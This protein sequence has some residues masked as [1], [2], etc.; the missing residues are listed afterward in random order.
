MDKP[1]GILILEIKVNLTR[2]SA[3]HKIFSVYKWISIFQGVIGGFKII[4][5][6]EF[7]VLG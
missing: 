3:I 7:I 6:K 2:I 4:F 5:L 1:F